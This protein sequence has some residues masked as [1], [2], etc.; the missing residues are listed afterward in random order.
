MRSVNLHSLRTGL[1]RPLNA[2]DLVT[3]PN[4]LW[5]GLLVGGLISGPDDRRTVDELKQQ[6]ELAREQMRR[7][8]KWRDFQA[9]RLQE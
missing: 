8:A 3:M 6:T 2:C 4:D 7:E 1:G 9:D 5:K